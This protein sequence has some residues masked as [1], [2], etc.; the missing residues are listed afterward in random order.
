MS[1]FPDQARRAGTLQPV[2]ELRRRFARRASDHGEMTWLRTEVRVAR[3]QQHQPFG[4]Q[5]FGMRGLDPL[6]G[7]DGNSL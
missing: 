6:E 5:H 2:A 1:V 3:L 4:S 7:P